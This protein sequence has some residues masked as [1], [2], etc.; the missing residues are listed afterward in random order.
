MTHGCLGFLK[1]S[2]CIIHRCASCVSRNLRAFAP[3]WGFALQLAPFPFASNSGGGVP[4]LFEAHNHVCPTSWGGVGIC[5]IF[6]VI[7]IIPNCFWT[8]GGSINASHLNSFE[9]FAKKSS[10]DSALKT[11]SPR[12]QDLRKH[13][14]SWTFAILNFAL[15]ALH[16]VFK[17]I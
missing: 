8:T 10:Q 17:C 16:V 11:L 5:G 6:Q 14:A 1:P 15:W 2:T 7:S 9:L 4:I 3:N 12:W 13:S